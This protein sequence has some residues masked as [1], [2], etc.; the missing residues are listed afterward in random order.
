MTVTDKQISLVKVK[1]SFLS[2]MKWNPADL[3]ESVTAVV[4]EHESAQPKPL[5]GESIKVLSW[6][7]ARS[8]YSESWRRDYLAIAKQHQPDLIFLQEVSLSTQNGDIPELE[9]LGWSFAPN[10]INASE[11][12]YSGILTAA[13]AKRLTS[14]SLLTQEREPVANTPKVSLFVKYALADSADSLLAVNIHAINFVELRKFK[15]QIQAI[16]ALLTQHAGSIIFAGDFNTW[17]RARW[18]YL[19]GAAQELNLSAVSFKPEDAQNLKRFLRSPPLDYI[20][21]RGFNQQ[22]LSARV[23]D[24]PSSSDHNPLLVELCR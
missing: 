2:S 1:K 9:N 13:R 5:K 8:N 18:L 15:A 17:S 12:S 11:G 14:Q 3:F 23:I 20:F 19:S 16:A 24:T 22:P 4:V 6:N 10:F 7:I 21:Y